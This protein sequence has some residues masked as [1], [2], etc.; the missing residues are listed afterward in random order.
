MLLP[1][2]HSRFLRTLLLDPSMMV[3]VLERFVSSLTPVPKGKRQAP[4][5]A[6]PTILY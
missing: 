2:V 1:C 5:R 3:L 6:M 4:Q